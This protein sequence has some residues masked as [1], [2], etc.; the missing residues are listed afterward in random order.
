M[1]VVLQPTLQGQKDQNSMEDYPEFNTE[2][3]RDFKIQKSVLKNI[4]YEMRKPV[5]GFSEI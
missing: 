5:T 2:K 4:E 3:E 1:P